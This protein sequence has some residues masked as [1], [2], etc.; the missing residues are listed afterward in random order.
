LARGGRCCWCV[1][2]GRIGR[3]YGFTGERAGEEVKSC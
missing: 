1:S 2:R 3:S